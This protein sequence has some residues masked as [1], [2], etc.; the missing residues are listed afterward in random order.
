M[1][2]GTCHPK[3]MLQARAMAQRDLPNERINIRVLQ[4]GG[5]AMPPRFG[6]SRLGMAKGPHD[7]DEALSD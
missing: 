5:K 4:K 1:G 3:A 2:V 6:A 7:L